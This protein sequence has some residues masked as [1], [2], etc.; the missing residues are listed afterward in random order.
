M[1]HNFHFQLTATSER[2]LVSVPLAAMLIS[3]WIHSFSVYIWQRFSLWKHW[4]NRVLP[5]F[6]FFRKSKNIN[7]A[8]PTASEKELLGSFYTGVTKIMS[9][10]NI[11]AKLILHGGDA[12]G[13]KE[14]HLV[15]SQGF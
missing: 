14:F 6:F 4:S 10:E 9:S 1:Y 11:L 15:N 2:D 8:Q 13:C 12:V 5:V 7:S 3:K